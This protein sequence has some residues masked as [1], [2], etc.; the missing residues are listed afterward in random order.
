MKTG[1]VAEKTG[2]VR[3]LGLAVAVGASSVQLMCQ[4]PRIVTGKQTSES[5]QIS[6]HRHDFGIHL[7]LD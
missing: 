7:S 4:D 3:V 5:T 1:G 2:M 6:R